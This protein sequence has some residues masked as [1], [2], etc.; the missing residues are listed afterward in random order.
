VERIW[1]PFAVWIGL[2]A[3]YAPGRRM[4]AAQVVTG[5]LLQGLVVSPW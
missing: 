2:A 1:V 5:L 4:L 3:A